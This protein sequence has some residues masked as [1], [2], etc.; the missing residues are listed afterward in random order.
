MKKILG[1]AILAL[2]LNNKSFA[3]EYITYDCAGHSSLCDDTF[4][5]KFTFEAANNNN[6]FI[7][8]HNLLEHRHIVEITKFNY[9]KT[10]SKFNIK[11]YAINNLNNKFL[12]IINGKYKDNSFNIINLE[13]ELDGAKIAKMKLKQA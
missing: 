6:I 5:M 3:K 2:L 11:F 13:I 4:V 9:F 12:F 1:I 10:I 8:K 7:S